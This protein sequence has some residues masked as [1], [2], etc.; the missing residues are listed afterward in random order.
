MD[1]R[2]RIVVN[3]FAEEVPAGTSIQG[4]IAIF[5][6]G[7]TDLIVELNGAFLYPERYATT[8]VRPGDRIEFINP[9]FGG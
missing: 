8:V 4:L 5:K 1:D 2:V 6:E 9:N 3:G 7:D